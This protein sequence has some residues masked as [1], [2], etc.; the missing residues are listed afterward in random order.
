MWPLISSSLVR[1]EGCSL[2]YI[3]CCMCVCM[4]VGCVVV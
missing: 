2:L 1:D 4:E 3:A